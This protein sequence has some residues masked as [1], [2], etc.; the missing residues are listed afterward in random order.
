MVFARVKN[1]DG[2]VEDAIYR[3][4]G[5]LG[6]DLFIGKKTMLNVLRLEVSGKTYA[7]R[8]ES[9]RA[10]A[11]CFQVA[12]DGDSDIQLSMNELTMVEDWFHANARRYGLVEEF[13]LNG[14]I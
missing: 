13:S 5:E 8:K 7:E 2:I 4:M 3:S 14:I 6:H 9:L 1:A 12:D 10:C 11:I